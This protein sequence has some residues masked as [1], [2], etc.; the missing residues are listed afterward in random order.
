MK[1][2]LGPYG[3]REKKSSACRA[4]AFFRL[5]LILF[6]AVFISILPAA[7]QTIHMPGNVAPGDPFLCWMAS[8]RPVISASAFLKSSDG[9]NLS[10]AESFFMPSE[11]EGYLY[12]FL[13]AIPTKAAPGP[14]SLHVSAVFDG[15]GAGSDPRDKAEVSADFVIEA[16]QFMKEDIAL[17]KANTAIRA[18]P[19]PAKA[20][21]SKVFA[22]IFDTRDP[23]A[24][25]AMDPM[26]KP[27]SVA[28][29]ETAGFGDERRYIYDGGGG[30]STI[31]GGIDLGAKTGSEVL[32][33]APGRVVFAGLRIVTGNT[34]VLE[35]L[36]GLF[37]LYM[38]LSAI[39]VAEGDMV[40]GGE[41]IGRV[42]STGLST[43]PHLH[44]E[45]RVGN[46]SVNPYY[47]LSRSL[48]SRPP[49]DK[50][51]DSSKIKPPAEGR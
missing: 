37:S 36:P 51:A 18:K 17:D 45:I 19:D 8:D 24:L 4:T 43:G 44:W 49:L 20:A 6:L 48:L 11:G 31:H 13:L 16:K 30:D 2:Y 22:D 29:R 7:A 1:G 33:C 40:G 41:P 42:G 21:E 50:D 39:E 14:G 32:A 28:W 15:S 5:S 34:L 26:V 47:W 10:S 35:H 46:V 9:K 27:L 3:A 23:T 38:H 25:F 12:G